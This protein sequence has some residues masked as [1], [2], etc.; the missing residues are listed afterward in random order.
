MLKRLLKVNSEGTM[1]MLVIKNTRQNIENKFSSFYKISKKTI[2][3][4]GRCYAYIHKGVPYFE[5]LFF[6]GIEPNAIHFSRI[7]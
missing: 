2:K 6:P 5:N 1:S 3:W 7:H 4:K